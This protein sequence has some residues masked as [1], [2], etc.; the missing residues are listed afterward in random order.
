MLNQEEV[1]VKVHP[2]QW[3]QYIKY[4]QSFNPKIS[5]SLQRKLLNTDIMNNLK[6]RNN[7]NLKSQQ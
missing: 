3:C 7:N 1:K 4:T 2:R 6:H 5:R